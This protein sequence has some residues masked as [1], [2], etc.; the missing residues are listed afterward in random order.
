[1]TIIRNNFEG[2]KLLPVK[3]GVREK[4]L[5]LRFSVSKTIKNLSEFYQYDPQ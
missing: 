3:E 2:C 5:P 1:M 4:L